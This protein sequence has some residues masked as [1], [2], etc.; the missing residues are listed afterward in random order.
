MYRSAFTSVQFIY[1]S[2]YN[3]KII[4]AVACLSYIMRDVTMAIDSIPLPEGPT[5]DMGQDYMPTNTDDMNVTGNETESWDK[6]VDKYK[7]Q[8]EIPTNLTGTHMDDNMNVTGNETEPWDKYVDKYKDQYE[9][10]YKMMD[11]EEDQ[12]EN[13]EDAKESEEEDKEDEEEDDEKD[14]EENKDNET[15]YLA[16]DEGKKYIRGSQEERMTQQYYSDYSYGKGYGYYGKKGGYGKGYPS[17]PSGPGKGYYYGKK[18]GYGY[19]GYYGKKGGYGKGYPSSP[20]GPSG[21]SP[22]WSKGAQIRHFG[23]GNGGW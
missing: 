17:G 2:M 22:S 1:I 20:S 6:Y 10:K 7:D 8:Y 16:R 13:E 12:K 14:E 5:H 4:S 9:S 18:G 15:R 21:P 3:I 23:K 11:K 19:G